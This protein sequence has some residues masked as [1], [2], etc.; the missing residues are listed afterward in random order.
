MVRLDRMSAA[1]PLPNVLPAKPTTGTGP[2]GSGALDTG[3]YALTWGAD[4][5]LYAGNIETNGDFMRVDLATK[6]TT[7]VATFPT[8]VTAAGLYD[9]ARLMVATEGGLVSLLN[10][11]TGD[12]SDLVKLEAHVTSVRRDKF[13]GKVYAEV[14]T[15]PPKILEITGDGKVQKLFQNP[16]R[17]G[18]IAIGPDNYLY[19]LSVYPQVN[20]KAKTSIVR[21]PLPTRR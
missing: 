21:W 6:K 8:R 18:R 15:T 2:F 4:K 20:W 9:V 11:S 10:T 17:L 12:R 7:K 5:A 13:T 1:R 14:A 19:H 3:P 16:P